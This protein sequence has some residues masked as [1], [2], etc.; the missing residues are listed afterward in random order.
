MK[1]SLIIPVFNRSDFI[2]ETLESVKNQTYS[3]WECV[4]VDDG[5]TDGTQDIVRDYVNFDS[6]FKFF[7]RDRYPKGAPTCRNIGFEKSEGDYINWFDSDDLLHPEMLQYKVNTLSNNQNTDFVVCDVSA[8]DS[9]TG[10]K[11]RSDY[12]LHSDNE[13]LDYLNGTYYFITGVPM[14]RKSFLLGKELFNPMLIRH[15][16]N[17]LFLRLLLASNE[18]IVIDKPLV[19]KREHS[20][21]ISN[22]YSHKKEALVV[23]NNFRFKLSCYHSLQ[24]HELINGN[25]YQKMYKDFQWFFYYCNKDSR[26]YK[27]SI[28][29]LF[30]LIDTQNDQN[31]GLELL[32]FY[33]RYFK[34]ELIRMKI[35]SNKN[36]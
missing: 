1:V 4:V 10:E 5:S 2:K 9:I 7:Q 35:L 25:I 14:F 17:E 8:F 19:L 16:E 20:N 21:N 34:K 13:I 6:R 33:I 22:T 3:N 36:K 27:A 31:K 30:R 24:K 23:K 28:V 32:K 11:L 15:Q 18:H 29:L 26:Y 12:K